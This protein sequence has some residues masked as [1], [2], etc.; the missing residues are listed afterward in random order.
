[1]SLVVLR[2]N[3]LLLHGTRDKEARAPR[4]RHTRE[5]GELPPNQERR[6]Y[7]RGGVVPN[8]RPPA[9]SGRG[10]EEPSRAG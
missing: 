10:R 9:T 5:L 6:E 1:M 4:G 3:M 2:S 8:R 7:E